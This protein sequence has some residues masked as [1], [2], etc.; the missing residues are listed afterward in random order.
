MSTHR[1]IES[2]E[3][4]VREKTEKTESQKRMRKRQRRRQKGTN[5]STLVHWI[6]IKCA[7]TAPI[8]CNVPKNLGQVTDTWNVCQFNELFSFYCFRSAWTRPRTSANLILSPSVK[9]T[10]IWV[11]FDLAAN[12]FSGARARALLSIT[13]DQRIERR[14]NNELGKYSLISNAGRV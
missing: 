5:A 2:T 8:T 11:L 12:K 6:N 9:R 1:R 3:C 4:S 14:P 7:L 10:F 13:F